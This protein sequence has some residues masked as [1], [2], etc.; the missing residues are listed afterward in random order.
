MPDRLA[1][2]EQLER[3]ISD[4]QAQRSLL[5]DAVVDPAIAALRE[6]L[7]KRLAPPRGTTGNEE[8]K[9]VTIM[10]ADISGFTQ[11]A[12]QIDAEE[13]RELVNACFERFAPV[14]Q[15]YDGTIDK[16]LGDAI[17]VL[18]GAPVAHEN[19]PERALRAALEMMDAIGAFNREHT[20]EL[21][22]HAGVNTGP[23]VAGR[24]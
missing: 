21:D 19:D 13:A 10:F 1:T 11:L 5:G 14:I 16:F 18:F 15:R 8:R 24:E 12:E 23:V 7:A 9:I 17:M 4:L 20:T 22:I 6:Q 2:K 3:A